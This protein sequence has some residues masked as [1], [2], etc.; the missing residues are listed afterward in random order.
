MW[1]HGRMNRGFRG[2]TRTNM[3]MSLRNGI[4]RGRPAV[5]L[6]AEVDES[7]WVD[8]RG[9]LAHRT[10]GQTELNYVGVLA[11]EGEISLCAK[12]VSRDHDASAN[13]SVANLADIA[14][15]AAR[16]LAKQQDVAGAVGN[17]RKPASAAVG[18]HSLIRRE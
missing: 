18:K 11:A 6:A 10:V 17:L 14:V 12:A 15:F 1:F 13:P 5:T 16:R 9:D 4:K 3:K 7:A 8:R 2:F